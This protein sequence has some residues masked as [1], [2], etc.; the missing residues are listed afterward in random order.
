VNIVFTGVVFGFACYLALDRHWDFLQH[1]DFWGALTSLLLIS[2]TGYWVND[3]FDF[4]IDRVNKPRKTIVN[5]HLSAKKVLTAYFV[6]VLSV[7]MVSWFFQP[8]A[9]FMVNL[10]AALLLFAYAAW[11]KRFSV[12][13]NLLIAALAGLVVYYAGLLY[14]FRLS[15]VWMTMF[16]FEL[17]FIREVTKDIEDIKGDLQF[18]LQTLPIRIGIRA[19][20]TFLVFAYAFFILSCYVPFFE[21]AARTGLANWSYLLT[22][23]AIVQL[24]AL[25]LVY[26]LM[27]SGKPGDFSRQ[28]QGL[29]LLIIPG[30]ASLLFLQ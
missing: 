2:A 8:M 16:A 3:V 21:E 9:I 19:T 29:K 20:R 12:L 6:I 25:N 28:S 24:P 13:G 26:M 30:L 10:S 27:N 23:I 15:M 1:R 17:T 22:S 14:P 4:K 5:A 11:F 7:L 18:K